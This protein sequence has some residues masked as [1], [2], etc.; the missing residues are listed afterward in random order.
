MNFSLS[1]FATR[2]VI[3]YKVFCVFFSLLLISGCAFL[4]LPNNQIDPKKQALGTAIHLINTEWQ[5]EKYRFEGNWLSNFE[6]ERI[7][8]VFIDNHHLN[9]F[10]GC[11]AFSGGYKLKNKT[12]LISSILTTKK[13]CRSRGNIVMHTEGVFLGLLKRVASYNIKGNT[14]VLFDNSG[15]Q[16][17]LFK[18]K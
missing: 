3:S 4:G 11:N 18:P 12:L 7:A 10:S 2:V 9:G 17:L 8:I 14:L 6:T 15:K 1:F 16:V 5:L 13:N